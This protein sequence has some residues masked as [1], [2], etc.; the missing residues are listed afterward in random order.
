MTQCLCAEHHHLYIRYI[1][2]G[3]Y[4][5]IYIYI[6]IYNVYM[7]IYAKIIKVPWQKLRAI[8]ICDQTV[9]VFSGK[10]RHPGRPIGM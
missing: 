7:P 10:P 9:H 2:I 3:I 8:L 4:Q 1:S 5:Y 6:P